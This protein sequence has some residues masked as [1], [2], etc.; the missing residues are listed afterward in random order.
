M[1][2]IDWVLMQV[3]AYG[4][5]T[6]IGV[7]AVVCVAGWCLLGVVLH[8]VD[9][10]RL[11]R[12]ETRAIA[13]LGEEEPAWEDDP[14]HGLAAAEAYANNPAVRAAWAHKPAPKEGGHA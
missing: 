3:D 11:R 4:L 5:P 6:V 1:T 8:T 14:V 12:A 9:G 7:L 2:V 10:C 13:D